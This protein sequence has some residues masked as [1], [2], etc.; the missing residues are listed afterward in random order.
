MTSFVELNQ[1]LLNNHEYLSWFPNAK[2]ISNSIRLGSLDG[3]TGSSLW[4]CHKRGCWKDHATGQSGGDLISLY[5]A[6][7]KISQNEARRELIN[8]G[9]KRPIITP[10]ISLSNRKSAV[11]SDYF[12]KL[13]HESKSA[14]GTLVEKYLG[15]RGIRIDI[16]DDIRFIASH[17]HSLSKQFFPVMICAIR[18]AVTGHI[19]GVHRTWLNRDGYSK[20]SVTNN[21]QMLG[22]AKGG[23][24]KLGNADKCLMIA[25]GI[26]T[27]LSVMQV[28]GVATWAALSTSGLKALDLPDQ[29]I[30]QEIYVACDNDIP[31]LLSASYAASKW[32]QEGR[33]VFLAKPPEG[34]DFN[35]LLMGGF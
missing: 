15:T 24:I 5:A 31:G 10:E 17:R 28:K 22:T 35:D 18:H 23:V 30:A 25:E 19:I 9:F 4:I 13:W 14:Q 33:K 11:K 6:K 27:A 20:A 12:L 29:P 1:Q 32:A 8:D 34:K 16:P 3:E 7:Y 21:K 2:V 26:E